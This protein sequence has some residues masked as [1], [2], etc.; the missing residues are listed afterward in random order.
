MLIWVLA[1]LLI[2]LTFSYSVVSVY[3]RIGLGKLRSSNSLKEPTIS[4][5]LPVRNERQ[6]IER[7][8]T[9]LLTQDYPQSKYEIIVVD[10]NSSDGT[11]TLVKTFRKSSLVR[12]TAA[13]DSLRMTSS[14]AAKA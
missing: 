5:I 14:S 12:R 7:C 6:T 13:A 3:V 2:F 11:E 10:D 1:F 4:V 8:L 9:S